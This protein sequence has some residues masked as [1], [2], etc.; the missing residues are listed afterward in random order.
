MASFSLVASAWTSTIDRIGHLA[1]GTG[2]ELPVDSGEGIVERV[3]VEAAHDVDHENPVARARVDEVRAPSRSAGRVVHRAQ[4]PRLAF[5]EDEGLALVPGMVA[6]GD[7]VGAGRQDLVADRL[8]DAEAAGGVLAVDDDAV[9]LPAVA[10]AG[11]AL[12][13]RVAAGPPDDVAE[14]E[15]THDKSLCG[16][17]PNELGF[18]DDDVEEPVMGLDRNLVDLL[19]RISEP[20]RQ[21]RMLRFQTPRWPGRNDPCRSRCALPCGRRRRGARSA[22]WGRLP[23]HPGRARARR[24]RP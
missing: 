19:N 21:D 5:D 2:L 24:S 12:D 14:E 22:P 16:F 20:D 1:Q 15:K 6:E 3:H 9:E 8:G 4:Q 23:A 17:R 7:G 11:Q 13:H 10:K 18:R